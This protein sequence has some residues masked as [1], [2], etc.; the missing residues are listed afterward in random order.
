[1]TA[2]SI[3]GLRSWS[4][5]KR[6]IPVSGRGA[7]SKESRTA[8][9]VGPSMNGAKAVT[10]AF[11]VCDKNTRRP[12]AAVLC[13]DRVR[14]SP[15]SQLIS[16]SFRGRALRVHRTS[17]NK[18]SCRS[19]MR[20]GQACAHSRTQHPCSDFPPTGWFLSNLLFGVEFRIQNFEIFVNH[21]VSIVVG[22]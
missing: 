4:K 16:C 22:F 5:M 10:S 19:S 17:Q 1:M 6:D 13:R 21:L 9:A 2:R 20:V 7:E 14:I 3:D 15:F 12:K 11:E 8:S 18:H